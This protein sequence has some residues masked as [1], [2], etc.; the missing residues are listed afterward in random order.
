M[1]S[2]LTGNRV[3]SGTWGELWLDGDYVAEA[4][5]CQAKVAFDKEEIKLAGQMMTDQKVLSAKGTGTIGMH[6]V[7]SR[8]ARKIGERILDGRDVRFT[9]IS[10]L[11][12]PD[13]LG[14]ERVAYKNVSFDDLTLSDFEVGVAGKIETPFTFTDFEFLDKAGE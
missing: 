12:D 3:M 6:K 9:V 10:K 1:R 13:A 8:M 2:N 14:A 5:K 7:N 11:D 4:Y